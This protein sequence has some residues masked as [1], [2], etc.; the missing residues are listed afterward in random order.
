MYTDE[1]KMAYHESAHAVADHVFGFGS[2]YISTISNPTEGYAGCAN[3]ILGCKDG[4]ALERRIVSLCAGYA[5]ECL[6]DPALKNEA[7]RHARRD[8]EL[9]EEVCKQ[10]G[11][12]WVETDWISK[13]EAFVQS[14]W[15][16]IQA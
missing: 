3:Q 4:E 1:E 11:R 14:N 6:I 10:L 12:A 9:A 8:F 13:A 15:S 7:R 2:S 16:A 5:A